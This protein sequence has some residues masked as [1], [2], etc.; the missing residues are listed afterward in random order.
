VNLRSALA[1][2]FMPARIRRLVK[3]NELITGY[4]VTQAIHVAAK[5]GIPDVLGDR[6]VAAADVATAVGADPDAVYRLLRALS[7]AGVTLEAPD[8]RFSLTMLGKQLRSGAAGSMRNWAIYNGEGWHWRAWGA[9]LESTRAGRTAMQNVHGAHLFDFLAHDVEAEKVFDA[10]MADLATIDNLA[11]VSSYRFPPRSKI[12][13]VGG[14]NG[15][16]LASLLKT[17]PEVTGTLY[18]RPA[19][20]EKARATLAAAGVDARADIEEGDFFARVPSGGDVYVLKQVLHDWGDERATQILNTC[21]TAMGPGA[22]LLVI[23][24]VIADGPAAQI[25]KLT[26]LE[27]LTMTGG[28]ERTLEEY[29]ALA[30]AAGFRI[31]GFHATRTPF[32]IVECMRSRRF[33]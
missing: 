20:A 19:V 21:R 22:R 25:A 27:M 24:I 18:D 12:V 6:W 14:G 4:W 7:A 3:L 1:R 5:L 26:D 16:L 13:D 23:E 8:K 33:Y 29:R 32:S 10:A 9:L 28:R 11:L 30:E 17:F 2:L 31:V 15:A